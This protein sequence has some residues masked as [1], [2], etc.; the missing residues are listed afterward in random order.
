A[1]TEALKTAGIATDEVNAELAITEYG[2]RMAFCVYLPKKYSFDP[3]DG[4]PMAMRLE[5][6]NSV[7]GSTR[8][9]AMVGWFRLV[10]RNGLVVGV[11]QSDIR[12]RHVG[13]LSSSYVGQVLA[14]GLE[15]TETERDNFRKWRERSIKPEKMA[16]WVEKDLKDKWGFKAA[17]RF[18]HIARQGSDVEIVGKY[19]GA[20]PTTILTRQTRY[21][22]GCPL[23]S[24]NLF[25][26]SQVLAWL[27]KERRDVQEQLEWREEIPALLEPLMKN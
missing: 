1:A 17:T 4:H 26:V 5:C 23:I 24:E 27:A 22:P 13:D 14:A 3:G 8:F 19:E 15:N 25:D 20:S 11:T 21:V 6:I 12:R 16:A 9:R 18:Y 7:D 10:C 2:E